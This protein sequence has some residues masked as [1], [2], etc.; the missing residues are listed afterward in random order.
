MVNR[1]FHWSDFKMMRLS[2]K[3]IIVDGEKT[4]GKYGTPLSLSLGARV[5]ERRE[6]KKE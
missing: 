1:Q 5:K 4:L 6:Q 2:C 3:R